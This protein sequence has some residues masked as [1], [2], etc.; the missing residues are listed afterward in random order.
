MRSTLFEKKNCTPGQIIII[1]YLKHFQHQHS[2]KYIYR[3]NVIS[4]KITV[5]VQMYIFITNR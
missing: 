4:T 1:F 3:H 2:L 5:V